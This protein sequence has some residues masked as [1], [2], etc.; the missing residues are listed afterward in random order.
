M[1]VELIGTRHGQMVDKPDG[2]QFSHQIFTDTP[3]TVA[4][5]GMQGYG[6]V[7]STLNLCPLVQE[8]GAP[9]D[10]CSVSGTEESR[11][12]GT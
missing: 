2:L 11:G 3:C 12:G 8:T 4:V 6:N 9:R 1:E 10:L 5:L 7:L